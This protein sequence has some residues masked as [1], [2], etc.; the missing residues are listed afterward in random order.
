M[1]SENS[2]V[3]VAFDFSHSGQS[4]LYRAVALVKRAPFH[5]LHFICAI[6]PHHALAAVPHHGPVDYRYAEQVQHALTDAV[7]Q[8]LRAT[9][10]TGDV[11]FFVH[12]RIGK[13]A[14]EILDL[15]REVGADLIIIG[16]KGLTGVERF[17]LGSVS[18]RVVREAHCTVEVTRPKT[19]EHVDL[20]AIEE[21]TAT[22]NYVP[23]HRYTYDQHTATLRPSDWPL[24]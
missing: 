20:M 23:P 12:A 24:Y 9:N 14:E 17:A 3:V 6:E 1:S 11:Q 8:E 16:S 7:V 13:P 21:T 22:H 2:Q 10:V 18:E 4:A 5:V 19:Y 15:A